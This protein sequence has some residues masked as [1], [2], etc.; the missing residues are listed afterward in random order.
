M[1]WAE[2]PA[3]TRVCKTAVQLGSG[4]PVAPFAAAD[5]APL[6]R[7]AVPDG[8]ACFDGGAAVE[9]QADGRR[10]RRHQRSG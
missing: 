3:S 1:S 5:G 9:Q 2:A 7:G 6:D 10:S 4:L 8:V